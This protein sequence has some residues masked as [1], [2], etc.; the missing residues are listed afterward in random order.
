MAALPGQLFTVFMLS[1]FRKAI[2]AA[3]LSRLNDHYAPVTSKIEFRGD[4]TVT[5]ALLQAEYNANQWNK[6]AVVLY[7]D[8]ACDKVDRRILFENVVPRVGV[9]RHTHAHCLAPGPPFAAY[10]R[11]RKSAPTAIAR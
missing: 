6:H 4:T 9:H 1:H 7:L 11:Q 2:V 8:K 10:C 5:Q 3:V